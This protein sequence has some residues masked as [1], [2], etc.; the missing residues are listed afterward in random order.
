MVHNTSSAGTPAGNFRAG[1]MVVIFEVEPGDCVISSSPQLSD[2]FLDCNNS[3]FLD[4][5]SNAFFTTVSLKTDLYPS[6]AVTPILNEVFFLHTCFSYCLHYATIRPIEDCSSSV[7]LVLKIGY[8]CNVFWGTVS[9]IYYGYRCDKTLHSE[10][11]DIAFVRTLCMHGVATH[12]C[13]ASF[14]RVDHNK[15][16]V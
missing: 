13:I 15:E 4:T 14:L 11:H 8:K 6:V 3:S 5:I 16:V 1:V 10:Q 12:H 2:I 9:L 7:K